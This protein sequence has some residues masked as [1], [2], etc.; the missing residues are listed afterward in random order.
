[1]V[2]AERVRAVGYLRV[3]SQAQAGEEKVSLTEQKKDIQFYC[4]DH[5]YEVV[6]WYEDIGSGSSKRRRSFQRMLREAPRTTHMTSSSL[7]R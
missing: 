7:G 4:D 1:M 6:E 3:S 2:I 5:G